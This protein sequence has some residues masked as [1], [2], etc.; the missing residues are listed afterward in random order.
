MERYLYSLSRCKQKREL[1]NSA[2]IAGIIAIVAA[3]FFGVLGLCRLPTVFF[4]L[5]AGSGL[6][7]VL[8]LWAAE[9]AARRAASDVSITESQRKS[10]P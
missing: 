3:A 1:V 2:R 7:G 9:I 5:A 10:D 4:L 6:F 8:S